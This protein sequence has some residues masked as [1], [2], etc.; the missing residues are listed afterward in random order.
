M[1][2]SMISSNTIKLAEALC[3]A[4]AQMKP[5][6]KDSVNPYH[7]SVYA[8]LNSVWEAVRGPLTDNGLAISQRTDFD[9]HG[10]WLETML[11][12]TSGE[13][14]TSRYPI[15][16]TMVLK[17]GEIVPNPTSQGYGAA[18]TYA[19]RYCLASICGCVSEVDD[20]GNSA[21]IPRQAPPSQQQRQDPMA[22]PIDQ[23]A[24]R[25][26]LFGA[27]PKLSDDTVRETFVEYFTQGAT[28][29]LAEWLQ[30]ATRADGIEML[31]Q[32]KELGHAFHIEVERKE[33][34]QQPMETGELVSDMTLANYSR[35]LKIAGNLGID[36]ADWEVTPEDLESTVQ[37]KG[38][39]LKAEVEAA[40]KWAE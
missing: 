32:A 28:K 36:L 11:L 31:K 38:A 39:T 17:N 15:N 37:A 18:I 30:T 7:K 2:G 1:T 35:L 12:H 9:E 25:K 5:A 16:P 29:S 4:Q 26:A 23:V 40:K 6:A 24:F 13:Y 19:R 8:D 3:K 33:P 34:E 22:A 20:D 14:I 21:S 10:L 27:V